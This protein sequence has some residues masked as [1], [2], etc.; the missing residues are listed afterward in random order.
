MVVFW[1]ILSVLAYVIVVLGM[2]RL[3]KNVFKNTKDQLF[4]QFIRNLMAVAMM[5]V[6]VLVT[7]SSFLPHGFTLLLAGCM[8]LA[9]LLSSVSS[10]ECYRHGPVGISVLIFSSMAMLISTLS[11]P[12]FW[13]ES[14]SVF[15]IIG[16]VL[17]LAS[18]VLLTEKSLVKKASFKWIIFL[19]LAG[20][21]GGA[22][23]PIQKVLAT[24]AYAGENIEFITYTF[25]FCSVA[26]LIAF[27]LLGNREKEEKVTYRI[28]G[29][30]LALFLS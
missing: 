19:I 28:K 1:L 12:I 30:V 11:G 15:Q 22:Q 20:I 26:S 10:I 21:G 4:F 24:S 29:T 7:K 6:I 27:F 18:M 23:G 16:I 25:V 8:G 2:G 13:H 9:T 14:I 3:G 17:S 5:V